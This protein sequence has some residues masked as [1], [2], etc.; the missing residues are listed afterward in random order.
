MLFGKRHEQD[1]KE[2]LSKEAL[3]KLLLRGKSIEE[4]TFKNFIIDQKAATKSI[5]TLEFILFLVAAGLFLVPFVYAMNGNFLGS[6]SLL[7]ILSGLFPLSAIYLLS[8]VRKE[9][10]LRSYSS[11]VKDREILKNSGHH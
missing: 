3:L 1:L 9:K 10:T 7:F 6:K 2:Y 4:V 8:N 11:S 5:R